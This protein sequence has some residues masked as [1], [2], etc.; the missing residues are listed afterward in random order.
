MRI[1]GILKD[2]IR[3]RSRLVEKPAEQLDLLVHVLF[4]QGSRVELEWQEGSLR[5]N[6]ALVMY[7][8]RCAERR[9]VVPSGPHGSLAAVCLSDWD[10]VASVVRDLFETG[11]VDVENEDLVGVP[12]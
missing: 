10:T 12:I 5:G 1:R 11:S 9:R 2:D 7:V 8:E 6:P 4:C 3:T